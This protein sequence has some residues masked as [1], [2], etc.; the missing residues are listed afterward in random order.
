MYRLNVSYK[1]FY[2]TLNGIWLFESDPN[3]P[4][5]CSGPGGK[6]WQHSMRGSRNCCLNPLR[7]GDTGINHRIRSSKVRTNVELLP[8]KHQEIHFIEIGF[9][10]HYHRDALLKN[11]KIHMCLFNLLITTDV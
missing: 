9:K 1:Q 2:I 3:A 5:A 10:V 6:Q 7:L 4:S 8:F 11:Y